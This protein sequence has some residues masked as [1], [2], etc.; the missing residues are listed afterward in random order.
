MS[1]ANR[2]TRQSCTNV[3]LA[4]CVVC[5]VTASALQERADVASGAEAVRT[6][7][8]AGHYAD[9][10]RLASGWAAKIEGDYGAD[11]L[12]TARAAAVRAVGADEVFIIGG[13]QLYTEALPFTDRLYLTL[14]ADEKEADS[15]FP[16][17]KH[18][19]T[20]K[21]F[22]ETREWN[23]LHYRWLDLER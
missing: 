10:D 1:A 5:G 13:G 15:Y 19:F 7:L 21:L 8:D 16:E 11:S 23:G 14:I 4:S 22:E 6:A 18:E 9:A 3:I 17:Y 12:E 2:R 20:K